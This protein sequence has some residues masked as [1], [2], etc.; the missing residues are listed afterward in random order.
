MKTVRRAKNQAEGIELLDLL[1]V[2][3]GNIR[4]LVL[5]PI[6]VALAALGVTFVV[7]PTFTAT[8]RILQP[9]QHQSMAAM[10]ESQLGVFAALAGL[11]VRSPLETCVA[12]LKSRTITD[13]IVDRFDLR[14]VYGRALRQDARRALASATRISFTR[15]GLITIEVT[16]RDPRR[17]AD[18]ANTYVQEL[19]GLTSA[20]SIAEAEN[21]RAFFYEQRERS[22]QGLRE[23]EAALARTGAG[24][25]LLKLAPQVVV[26]RIGR[27]QGEVTA[28]E[29]R[30]ATM[31]EYLTDAS[32]EIRQ[33]NRE[34]ASLRAQV[35]QL[36]RDHPG[37][38][39]AGE[40]YVDRFRSF[41][42]QEILF[43][44]LSTQFEIGRLDEAREG[45][46]VQ[47]VDAAVVPERRSGPRRALVAAA[48]AIASG[49]ALLVFVVVRDAF[50]R[51]LS[52]GNPGDALPA[53]LVAW[54]RLVRTLGRR[55]NRSDH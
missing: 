45:P 52:S 46:L 54:Q 5:G 34:L 47:R 1:V 15:Y 3:A 53:I 40:A 32:P 39:G 25:G 28:Q 27:L 50:R 2:I 30:I 16:D 24:E 7:Q 26:A 17:A 10:I 8:T 20:M 33:A 19:I 37:A 42:Y 13:K 36:R 23:A 6:A 12:L 31:R 9:Q 43:E 38:S 41:K 21:R 51:T 49:L 44:L 4:L 35:A 22:Q 55:R 14:K 48:A 29:I 11:N 18:L